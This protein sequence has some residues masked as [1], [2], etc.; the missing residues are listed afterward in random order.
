[1][2]KPLVVLALG[3]ILLSALCTIIWI[4]V[5]GENARPLFGR[6]VTVQETSLQVT[7]RRSRITTVRFGTGMIIYRKNEVLTW[8][9]VPI[10]QFVQV[11]GDRLDQRTVVANEIRLMQTFD[12]PSSYEVPK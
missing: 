8:S 2:K 10:G 4:Y 5:N 1:M 11:T 3:G 9:E 7:D 6:V 12:A